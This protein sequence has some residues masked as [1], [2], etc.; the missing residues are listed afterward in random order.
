MRILAV[1]AESL[2]LQA[3]LRRCGPREKLKWPVGFARRAKWGEVTLYAVANGAGPRLA[4]RAVAAA[5]REA[6]PFDGYMSVGLCGALDQELP[7]H[8][9]CT[10]SVVGDGET[11]W[12]ARA[13]PETSMQRL[14]SIDRFLGQPEEKRRWAAEGFGIVEMEA[15]AVA[16]HAAAQGRP[17]RAAKVVS[18]I[19]EERFSLDFNEYRDAEG[20]FVRGRIA[21]AAAVHPIRY[22][23][24]LIRM[25][26]RGSAASETLGEFLAQSRF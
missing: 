2:E 9:V 26:S 7:L 19:A 15:A 11:N 3:W 8:A 5:E 21:L 4:A 17:F 24:D 10:A 20:R 6:G 13:W 25:A 18:D 12:P 16:K 22:A 23:S 14:L 1:A